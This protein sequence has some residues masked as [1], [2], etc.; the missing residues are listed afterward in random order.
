MN[1]INLLE[2]LDKNIPF[3]SFARNMLKMLMIENFIYRSN[4]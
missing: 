4:C 1:L 2:K 3:K